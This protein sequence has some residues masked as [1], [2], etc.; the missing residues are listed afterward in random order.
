M[1]K[2]KVTFE[3]AQAFEAAIRALPTQTILKSLVDEASTF[4]QA[5]AS[6]RPAD[7]GA[8]PGTS[9]KYSTG[10]VPTPLRTYYQRGKGARY[11]PGRS[12]DYGA[13]KAGR[14][15]RRGGK[16]SEDLKNSWR[17]ASSQAGF[18]VEVM[19]S[20]SYAGLV[21]GG[22]GDPLQQTRVMDARG[23]ETVTE[24]AQAV[25]DNIGKVM[26]NVVAAQYQQWLARNGI[27]ST[28]QK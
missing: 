20:V 28:T 8:T 27:S 6:R 17:R 25:E 2:S 12:T 21:Q 16:R 9:G 23:W 13:V 24:V 18:V 22:A 19:S 15:R 10:N 11:L 7:M 14:T 5:R 3:H 1:G 4:A 26:R